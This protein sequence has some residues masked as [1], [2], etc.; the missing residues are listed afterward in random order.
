MSPTL[1]VLACSL[2]WPQ[3]AAPAG[4]A[5]TVATPLM[6]PEAQWALL[7]ATVRIAAGE[8]QPPFATGVCVGSRTGVVYLLTANH[9]VPKGEARSYEFFDKKSYP[10]AVD[11]QFDGDVALRMPECDLA[12]VKIVLG[13]DDTPTVPL[14]K[15][16][17][18]P[19]RFPAVALAIG[20]PDGAAPQVRL[21]K[22]VGKRF[23]RRDEG[24]AFFWETAGA[25][26]GGMSGGPLFDTSGRLLGICTAVQAGQGY[27]T[28]LDEILATL[29]RNGFGWIAEAGPRL[30]EE[31][32]P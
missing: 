17:E 10:V 22:V 6:A 21:E 13:R 23:V 5:A 20:C 14:A 7:A 15:L 3:L 8:G 19:N 32:R 25:P 11:V 4:P 16:K 12:L 30:V 26:R 18:R 28:H 31:N 2:A 24:L 29:K 27:Y 9:S 1:F